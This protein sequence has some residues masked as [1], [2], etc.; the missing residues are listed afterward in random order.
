MGYRYKER[1]RFTFSL[2]VQLLFGLLVLLGACLSGATSC[3]DDKY[4]RARK[5]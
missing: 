2:V 3:F 5:V 4:D 1:D